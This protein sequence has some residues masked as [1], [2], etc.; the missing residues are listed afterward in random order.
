MTV[1]SSGPLRLVNG[2][3]EALFKA[4]VAVAML[5][6]SVIVVVVS[7]QVFS[8]YVA[9]TSASWAPEVAQ[10]AFVWTA[11]FAIAAGIREGRHMVV[12]AFSSVKSRGLHVILDT[13]AAIAV[14]GVSGVLAWY[15]YDSLS[16]SFRRVFPAL[17]IETG[18]M[19]L[20][21]P[22]GFALCM[23][24]GIENWARSVFSRDG[25]NTKSEVQLILEETADVN[26]GE[27][28]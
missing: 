11:I 27:V 20:A 3:L 15:G 13:V 5:G 21:V 17:G 19:F 26:D 6:L 8:R 16:I 2:A 12:D 28:R 18:W 7:W 23:V 9:G 24:F 4:T 1:S 10:L 25:A 14:V 22:V